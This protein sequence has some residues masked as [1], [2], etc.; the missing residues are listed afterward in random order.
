M[1]SWQ[2]RKVS[3][4]HLPRQF[5]YHPD[6]NSL[7]FGCMNGD[8]HLLEQTEGDEQ[9]GDTLPLGNFGSGSNDV[10]LGLCWLRNT[11]DR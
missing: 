11:Q 8:V 9:R 2:Y 7:L 5:E 4:K 1:N 10:I 6:G 3:G